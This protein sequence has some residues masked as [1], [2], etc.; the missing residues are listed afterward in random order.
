MNFDFEFT[1]SAHE[2]YLYWKKTNNQ[3][4]I[5]RI[6]RLLKDIAKTPYAGIGNPEPLK[7]QLSGYWS[8]RIDKEHRIVY[9]VKNHIIY[10]IS[11]RYHYL[12]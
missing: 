2:D 1:P 12:H 7:Y 3:K 4:V 6:K 8:R 9:K 11:M 5:N 10:I